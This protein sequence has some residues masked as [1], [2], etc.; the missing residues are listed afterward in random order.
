MPLGFFSLWHAGTHAV[1]VIYSC[2]SWSHIQHNYSMAPHKICFRGLKYA[3]EKT[4]SGE[5]S[6]R[7]KG[8]VNFSRMFWT[9]SRV[10]IV[11]VKGESRKRK[12]ELFNSGDTFP[13]ILPVWGL[14]SQHIPVNV[15]AQIAGFQAVRLWK[16]SSCLSIHKC[17]PPKGITFSTVQNYQHPLFNRKN[18]NHARNKGEM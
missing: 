10:T 3:S 4:Y 17:Q 12:K 2:V 13:S 14:C 8:D 15:A 11:I 16:H 1:C 9:L 6:Q 7:N 18:K 5:A